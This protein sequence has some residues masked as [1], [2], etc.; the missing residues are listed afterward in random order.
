MLSDEAYS[1]F[2]LNKDEFISFAELD[3]EKKHTIIINSL[4]KNFGISGWRL[5]YMISNKELINQTLKINQHLITCPSTILEYYMVKHFDDILSIT[6][7]QI[8][9]LIEKRSEI[10]KFLDTL[11]L[12]PLPGSSTFYFFISKLK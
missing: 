3:T 11:S 8:K 2:V 6:K 9:K 10:N 4:S 5:G 12:K 7:P 1:D